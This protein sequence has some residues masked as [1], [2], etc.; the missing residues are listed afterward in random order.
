VHQPNEQTDPLVRCVAQHIDADGLIAPHTT[1]LAG[2]SG[3]ADS[4]A[5]L[6]IL[7]TLSADPARDYRLAVAHLDHALRGDSVSDAAWVA[8]LAG[9]W[10]LPCV[11]RRLDVS[12]L[13]R[14][15]GQ[16]VEEAARTA[17]LAFFRR[18]AE[19]IGAG[20][21]AV[22]HH[23]DDNVETV[24]YRI[25]RGTHI[26]GLGGMAPSRPLASGCALVRP[27][28][29]CTRDDIRAYCSRASLEWCSDPTNADV[30]YRRNFIRHELLP[31]LREELNPQADQA[32]ARLATAA[33]EVAAVLDELAADALAAAQ[34]EE[35]AGRLVLDAAVLADRP[36]AVVTAAIRLALVQLGVPLRDIGADRMAD[37][38]DTLSDQ[39]R[40]ISLPGGF[41]AR[42]RAGRLILRRRAARVELPGDPWLQPVRLDLTA[43]TALPDGREVLCRVEPYDPQAF[44]DHCANRRPGTELLDAD[45]TGDVLHCGPRREGERFHPLGAPGRQT[46][47]DFLTNLRVP[48]DR[49][50]GVVCVRDGT[51]IVYVAPLR[52]DERVKITSATRRVL[53]ITLAG[54]AENFFVSG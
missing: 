35:Q 54:S 9:R 3:G 24:L 40:A 4:V 25:V 45:K 34:L 27:M 51:G 49:R 2:V 20:C 33:R 13:A 37:L 17:R 47:G 46:V 6:S 26:R 32:L 31:L 23:A 41:E 12:R 53:R 29:R 7:R 19:R 15:R 39:G 11:V 48:P 38:A 10:S 5:M 44:A 14:R 43:A 21:V 18:Q 22:G 28:L 16:G 42:R 1:V 36:H 30:T 50:R 8:D 52:I